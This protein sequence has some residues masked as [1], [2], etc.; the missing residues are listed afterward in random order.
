MILSEN[1]RK[2]FTA[3]KI[4]NNKKKLFCLSILVQKRSTFLT[5]TE[6]KSRDNGDADNGDVNNGNNYVD[7]NRTIALSIRCCCCCFVLL[8]KFFLF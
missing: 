2:Y 3:N 4:L 7:Y 1:F 5:S 6:M 8:S